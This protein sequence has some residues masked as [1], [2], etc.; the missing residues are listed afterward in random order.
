MIGLIE[1]KLRLHFVFAFIDLSN[2]DSSFMD[3]Q[4]LNEPVSPYW[5]EIDPLDPF[6][7]SESGSRG[8]PKFFIVPMSR[9]RKCGLRLIFGRP[10][11]RKL[12]IG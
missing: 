10:T 1:R 3:Q 2:A 11:A 12:Q 7:Y 6:A 4:R 9:E 5:V 8:Y